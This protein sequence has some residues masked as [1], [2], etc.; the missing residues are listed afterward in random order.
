MANNKINSTELMMLPNELHELR[1]NFGLD[2]LNAGQGLSS[3]LSYLQLDLNAI[4]LP[5]D[6]QSFLVFVVGGSFVKILYH[7]EGQTTLLTKFEL[8]TLQS[9]EQLVDLIL[10]NCPNKFL[11]CDCIILNFAFKLQPLVTN[12]LPDAKLISSSKGHEFP[13]LLEDSIGQQLTKY[14]QQKT[15]KSIPAIIISDM[16]ALCLSKPI[17]PDGTVIGLI[18]GTGLNLG[19][20]S[21][22]KIV[23]LEVGDFAQF[24]HTKSLEYVKEQFSDQKFRPLEF[25]LA[26]KYLFHHYNY[27][28]KELSLRPVSSTY[29]MIELLNT[30]VNT[31]QE[32]MV[33]FYILTLESEILEE[34]ILTLNQFIANE[35]ESPSVIGDGAIVEKL[36]E[37]NVYQNLIASMEYAVE[38]NSSLEESVTNL[39]HNLLTIP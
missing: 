14:I 36:Q 10:L 33:A 9:F 26:G 5:K 3:G 28:A 35:Q 8:P 32:W 20:S 21:H 15:N 39:V 22:G 19:F 31:D 38:L 17:N 6:Y 16:V 30:K 1:S 24:K 12:G 23:N 18:Q 37:T 25:M 2:L 7:K 27:Y 13:D 29:Q 34:I 4:K 11:D